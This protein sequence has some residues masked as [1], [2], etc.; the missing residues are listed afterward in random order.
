[1]PGIGLGAVTGCGA[2]LLAV[3]IGLALLT[4]SNV[5]GFFIPSVVV[6]VAAVALMFFP[7]WRRFATGILIVS[8]AMWIIVLG[9]CLGMLVP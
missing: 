4:I 1:M 3:V 5:I 2:Y 7:K 6:V 9:P 8:A